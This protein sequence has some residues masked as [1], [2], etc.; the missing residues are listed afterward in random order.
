[1]IRMSTGLVLNL[2]ESKKNFH[3]SKSTEDSDTGL[4]IQLVA[5]SAPN[6]LCWCPANVIFIAAMFQS[7][8]PVD[9]ILWTAVIGMP[10]NSVTNP[11]VF[12]TIS[13]RKYHISKKI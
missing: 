12:I 8:Y 7:T 9:L 4:V 2:K 13:V 5:I 6:I 1:M 11:V 3:K 10:L